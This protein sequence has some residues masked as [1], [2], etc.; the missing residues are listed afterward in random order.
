MIPGLMN[1]L[2]LA[3]SPCPND[4]FMFDA[5]ARNGLITNLPPVEIHL[6]D[7]E[8]LNQLALEQ[9]YDVSKVSFHAYLKIRKSYQLLRCGAALGRGC[10]PLVICRKKDKPSNLQQARIVLPGELTTAHL[11]FQLWQPDA[12]N[13]V[14][15][16]YDR[17]ISEVMEGRADAGVIIHESRF[18][19]EDLGCY[20][21]QDL[22]DWW[23]AETGLPIPLGGIVAR[24]S[25]GP[26]AIKQI[27]DRIEASIREAVASPDNPMPYIRQHA[28]ELDDAVI[29][30]HIRTY[31][32]AFSINLGEEGQAAVQR[33]EHMAV[34]RGVIT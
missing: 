33:L 20:S 22:G 1:A 34:E 14:F 2:T 23:T 3:Y 21:L 8:T 29:A 12:Q 24:K 13:K 30:R 16:T 11:L 25:L 5:I 28:Q 18:C 19:F 9:T 15:T 27:E 31:V 7:V 17:I 4:T 10:G 6:H 26:D 32:N